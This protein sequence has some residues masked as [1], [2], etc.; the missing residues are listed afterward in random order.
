MSSSIKNKKNSSPSTEKHR[1]KNKTK[2]NS[3]NKN[4]YLTKSPL[5]NKKINYSHKRLN[6]T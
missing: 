2:T 3:K 6:T 1:H 4:K 5:K